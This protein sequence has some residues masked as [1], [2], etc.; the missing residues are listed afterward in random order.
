MNKKTI[1]R[2]FFITL[3]ISLLIFIF[4]K[5]SN[6]EEQIEKKKIELIEKKI[7]LN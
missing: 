5:Y 3:S 6:K 7:K 4:L 1:L 2:I